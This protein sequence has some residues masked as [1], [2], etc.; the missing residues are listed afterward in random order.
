M[1]MCGYMLIE[2]HGLFAKLRCNARA[3]QKRRFRIFVS[4]RKSFSFFK[5]NVYV[6]LYAY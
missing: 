4:Y 1:F 5:I 6:W 3:L 2:E